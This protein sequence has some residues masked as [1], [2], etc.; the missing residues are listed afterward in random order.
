MTTEE[1]TVIE[2]TGA[3]KKTRSLKNTYILY[4]LLSLLCMVAV[5]VFAYFFIKT[6]LYTGIRNLIFTVSLCIISIFI[7][8]ASSIKNSFSYDDKEFPERFFSLYIIGILCSFIFILIPVLGWMFLFFY[9]ALTIVSNQTTGIISATSLLVL[10]SLLREITIPTFLIFF[11]SG[12]I[13]A[14]LISGVGKEFQTGIPISL[15]LAFQLMLMFAGDVLIQNK[16]IG[17][18]D[19]IIPVSNTILN[20]ILIWLFLQLYSAKVAR[21]EN[22]LYQLITDPEYE[23]ML[24]LKNDKPDLYKRGLHSAF[25]VERICSELNLDVRAAKCA[26]YYQHLDLEQL[27]DYPIPGHAL[28]LME[29]LKQGPQYMQEKEAIIVYICDITIKTIL[30]VTKQAKQQDVYYNRIIETL[31]EKQFPTL[32]F[33]HTDISLKDIQFIKKKLLQENMYYDFLR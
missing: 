5:N 4:G 13:G 16:K 1:T 31:F 28:A 6:D 10:T 12:I 23:A 21:K 18:E 26:A 22:N 25:L 8:V 20:C 32:L 14:A 33:I 9:I 15:S 11:I 3:K 19:A 2:K 17:W 30:Y 29:Q 7:Y 24:L 27:Q